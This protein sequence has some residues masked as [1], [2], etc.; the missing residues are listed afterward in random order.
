[1]KARNKVIEALVRDFLFGD[2]CI[3]TA[4]C[5]SGLQ[6]LPN[7]LAETARTIVL[8]IRRQKTDVKL[9]LAPGLLH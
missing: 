7:C 6:E 9:K 1:M 2:D 5:E 4:Y 8:T 3:L